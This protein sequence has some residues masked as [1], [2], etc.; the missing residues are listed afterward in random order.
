MDML[1][2]AGVDVG[3]VVKTLDGY[4]A[5]SLHETIPNFH[6]TPDRF[7]QFTDAMAKNASSRLENVRE[8][9]EFVMFREKTCTFLTD[10]LRAGKLPLRVTHNDTKMSNILFDKDT[11]KPVCIID[12][13]TIMPGLTAYDFGD[14]IRAGAT[15]AAE[16]EQDLDK[17]SFS[18]DRFKAYTKGFMQSTFKDGK[19]FLTPTEAETL[20]DG[21]IIMTLEVGMRFL[22]DYLNGDIYFATKYPEHN[23][24]RA[25][26]QFKLVQDMEKM[27]EEMR[28]VVMAYYSGN[29]FKL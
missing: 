8:D 2:L 7:R 18:L 14:S 19:S 27:S 23:L 29:E 17:V 6:N 3:S 24:H 26:N 1:E 13:D 5:D 16:D 11:G 15:T 21:A 28:S 20:S 4:P 12:L 9:C 10:L 25:R 22:A